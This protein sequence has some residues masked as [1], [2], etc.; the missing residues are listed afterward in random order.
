MKIPSWLNHLKNFCDYTTGSRESYHALFVCIQW[1]NFEY[2]I[3]TFI[4][5]CLMTKSPSLVTNVD[6][7]QLY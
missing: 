6:E 7:M 1:V 4:H 5:F 2:E 3:V